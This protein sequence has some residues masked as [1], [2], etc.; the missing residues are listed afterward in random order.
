LRNLFYSIGFCVF[1]PFLR[2]A[3]ILKIKKRSSCTLQHRFVLIVLLQK[4]FDPS[5]VPF[6]TLRS[7]D[8]HIRDAMLPGA[9]IK[10]IDLRRPLDGDQEL[11]FHYVSLKAE[12]KRFIANPAFR[13]KMYTQFEPEF[14]KERPLKRIFRR[15][16]SGTVFEYFQIQDPDASPAV[17]VLASDASFSGQNREHHPIYCKLKVVLRNLK[18]VA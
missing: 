18:N 8:K 6:K 5:S 3:H 16:N 9:E 17:F 10:T 11:K 12:L 15:A 7:L 1:R 2:K 4:S 14:T 13:G